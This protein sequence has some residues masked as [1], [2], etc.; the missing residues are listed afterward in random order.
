MPK[1]SDHQLQTLTDHLNFEELLL[2]ISSHFINLPVHKID[3]A[4]EDAQRRICKKMNIDVSALY[5]WS[6]E[7]QNLFT[8]THLYSPESGPDHPMGID[9][10]QAFPWIYNKLL[11]GHTLTLSTNELP[12]EASTDKKSRES[13][14]VKSSIAIPLSAG[15]EIFF[16]VISFDT[17][18]EYRTWS[19]NEINHLN[20]LA[21]ILTNAL[22]RKSKEDRLVESEARLELAAESAE[23]G[24]WDF[25]FETKLFWGTKRALSMFGFAPDMPISYRDF[26]N[27]IHPEDLKL[28]QNAMSLSVKKGEKLE[29]E[30]R[31]IIESEIV[32]WI[33]SR[34]RPHYHSD[35]SPN[36]MLGI[37]VDISER[38]QMEEKVK[39]SLEEVKRLKSQLEQEN[40]YL[41]EDLRTEQGFENIIG[42]SKEFAA[43]LGAARQVAPTAATVLLLGETGTGKGVVATAIHQ[44]SDRSS[45]PF[46]TVN[47]AALPHNLIESEL[48]GREKGAFTGAHAN[49]MGRFQVADKGTIFLDEIGEM[50]LEMQAKLLRVLQEGEF[51]R[52]GS[53]KTV[54]V[55]VRVIA[56]T[57]RNLKEDV[58]SGRFREDLF[59]RLNVYPIAI[60]PLRERKADITPLVQYF[61]N[62]YASKMGKEIDT[63]PKRLIEK[64][65]NYSWPGNVRELEHIIERS[66]IISSGPALSVV[67][68]FENDVSTAPKK[69]MMKDLATLERD[70]IEE[71]LRQTNWK[72]EGPGGAAAILNI[73]PSTL[74]FRLKK[75]DIVRPS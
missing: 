3:G 60:P 62:K 13:F 15:G 1:S 41:R 52:L 49:Q 73:H 51:E 36:R 63:I 29:I 64:M 48:F 34:A 47:C 45:H 59:Y 8:I 43:V 30:Y 35:G 61:T 11:A 74:R 44:M 55:D 31:I 32:K 53:P 57:G 71:V 75:L 67:D 18:S 4:I 39:Q 72:I 2:D 5:Q 10:S 19:E 6:N 37:S 25:N 58:R 14:G 7:K 33:C 54:K 65:M 9:A 40:Y 69:D 21:E 20:L 28:V 50:P 26:Q 27:S 16:G 46:V 70:H 22:L 12:A 66:V 17:L 42:T 24:L 23:L 56:A 38:K 68:H